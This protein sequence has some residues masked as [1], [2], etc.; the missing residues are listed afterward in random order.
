SDDNNDDGTINWADVT[1]AGSLAPGA[2]TT[3]TLH[4]TAKASTQQLANDQ[5]INTARVDGVIDENGD[6]PTGA[7]DSAPVEI[8]NPSVAISKTRTSTSPVLVGDE[9][10]FSIV[11]TNTGDTILNT[12]PLTDT[13][14]TTYLT[15]GFGGAYAS[16]ASDDNNDDGTINWADVT[17]AGSLAPGASTTVTLHFTAKASTQQLPNQQTINTARVDGVIDENGESPTG[18]EDTAPVEILTPA[19]L[20][21]FVWEDMNGDGV[22][23]AAENTAGIDGVTVEL[24]DAGNLTTPIAT[25]VTSGG[26]A[27]SFQHLFPG[28]YVVK[29]IKPTGYEFTLK[30]SPLTTLD[31][32][33]SDADQTTG[34]TDVITLTEGQN[35]TKWDAGL[36]R[37]VTIGDFI[38]RDVNANKIQDAG[39]TTGVPGV[40]IQIA[41]QTTGDVF[42]ATSTVTGYYLFDGLP[43][44]VYTITVPAQLPLLIRTTDLP[45]PFLMQSGDVDLTK[46]FG[47]IN[48]TAVEIADLWYDIKANG[49]LLQWTTSQEAAGDM[50]R[51]YRSLDPQGPGKLLTPEP[52]YAAG[53]PTG[54]SYYYLDTTAGPGATY[55][56]WIEV[57][58]QNSLIGPLEVPYGVPAPGGGGALTLFTPLVL[59]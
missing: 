22:Q 5:T 13:Y 38:F 21:D 37:P 46:D 52:L 28:N 53:N 56:Y 42:N 16:P 23:N 3:V 45:A 6:S 9:V 39:E 18:A 51:I 2:S 7:E 48:P 43:P 25:T 12:V 4:F 1:G 47:Y 44:G 19:S 17:G 26:G 41:N 36:Y 11:I 32:K 57:Q 20:G 55:Y 35:D 34:M 10:V 29:F 27:Y 14:D 8:G 30:D 54:S 49:V 24:Y 59:R 40:P 33:D 31:S 50:F 15:Y 58:P